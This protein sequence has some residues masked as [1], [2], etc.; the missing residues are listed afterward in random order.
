MASLVC[1]LSRLIALIALFGISVDA[2]LGILLADPARWRSEWPR[3]DFSKHSVPF[4]QI[5]SGGPPKDGI[6]PIDLPRFERLDRGK[7][8]GWSAG[9]GD[10][11]PVIA[12]SIDGDAHA[13]PLRVVIWHEI[14]NDTVGSTPVTVTYCPLCNAALVFERIVAGRVLDFGTTGKLRHSDLFMYDRQT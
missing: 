4:A 7:S 11:E 2:S 13:Y 9:L 1:N 14:V 3:T 12:L 5:R 6:P 10:T 8:T